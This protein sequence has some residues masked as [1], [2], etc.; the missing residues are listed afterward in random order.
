M[1]IKSHLQAGVT[2]IEMIVVVAIIAAVSSVIIFNYSDFSTNV[3]VRNLAQE[4][5]LSI[6]KAQ[7]YATSARPIEGLSGVDSGSFP[8]YGISF[9][10]GDTVT[11]PDQMTPGPRQ[12]ILFAET[13][14]GNE[15][16]YDKGMQCGNPVDGDECLESF[17]ITTADRITSICGSPN[18]SRANCYT[19]AQ[20][21]ITFRRP[22]P[23][24]VICMSALGGGSLPTFESCSVPYVVINLES[25]KGLKR[26]VMVWTTGQI[27]V[28]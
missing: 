7:T 21:D 19:N 24:A 25:A 3:S 14:G 16:S 8:G 27:S 13:R 5:A 10:T 18:T 11:P 9:A 2:L 22:S 20:V 6:R 12:F 4:V 17:G 26:A 15:N 23:D 28:Q 1:A